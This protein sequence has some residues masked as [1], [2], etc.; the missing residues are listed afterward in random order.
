MD[1][2]T[3]GGKDPLTGSEEL[4]LLS[5]D[6][7]NLYEHL[8]QT[9]PLGIKNGALPRDPALREL[10]YH[11]FAIATTT[12]VSAV[13]PE[14]ALRIA[15]ASWRDETSQSLDRLLASSAALERLQELWERRAGPA[16]R[17]VTLLT[18]PDIIGSVSADL[19]LEA[20][21]DVLTFSVEATR[22]KLVPVVPPAAH[23]MEQGVQFRAIWEK[24]CWERPEGP[25]NLARCLNA[26]SRI[27]LT[28]K[29][30][31]K[32]VLVDD[33]AALVPLTPT[34]TDAALLIRSHVL[35]G[36]LRELFESHWEMA[37]PAP[38]STN[39]SRI[40]Q[41]DPVA[42]MILRLL[43]AEVPDVVIA[44][45]LGISDR[46]LRRHVSALQRELNA[47]TRFALACAAMRRGLLD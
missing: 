3:T 19:T 29:L 21:R 41:A 4:P 26:G 5:E 10:L 17:L 33:V 36:A 15:L 47:S 30:P 43:A 13:A 39:Q 44:R 22:H 25:A 34:G 46:T 40:D 42:V 1:T 12:L 23:L 35:L 14:R 27:R 18:D 32:M 28:P 24:A 16:G 31:M 11:H 6:A 37:V 9:G 7:A 38:G 8:L 20:K 2:P 45:R